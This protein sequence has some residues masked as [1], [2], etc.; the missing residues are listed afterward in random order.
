MVNEGSAAVWRAARLGLG[1]R[2][3]HDRTTEPLAVPI[4]GSK[5]NGSRV[6]NH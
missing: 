6:E 3:E 2:I 4:T 5:R 1:D